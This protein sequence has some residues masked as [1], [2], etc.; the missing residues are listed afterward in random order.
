M[1]DEARRCAS[2]VVSFQVEAP[3]FAWP[4]CEARGEALPG[5]LNAAVPCLVLPVCE[6]ETNF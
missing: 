5:P 6:G 1:H 4:A 2:C 3:S